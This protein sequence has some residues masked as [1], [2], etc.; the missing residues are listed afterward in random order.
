LGTFQLTVQSMVVGDRPPTGRG[1]EQ[2]AEHERYDVSA[3]AF[4]RLTSKSPAPTLALMCSRPPPGPSSSKVGDRAGVGAD[5]IP[6]LA[7]DA[8][9]SNVHCGV[10]GDID[11]GRKDDPE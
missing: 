3:V 6:G 5:A 10:D 8:G 7:E 1:Q 2:Q 4:H 11:I 9:V